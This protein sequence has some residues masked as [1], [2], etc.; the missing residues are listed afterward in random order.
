MC[1]RMCL[2]RDVTEESKQ[3]KVQNSKI[4][5]DLREHAK[6]EMNVVKML[7]LGRSLRRVLGLW[8]SV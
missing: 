8:Y 4:E 1:M 7:M 2:H 5:E 3:A 6:A